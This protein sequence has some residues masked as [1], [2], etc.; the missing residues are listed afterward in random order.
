MK[1]LVYISDNI[2]TSAIVP[3][4]A[5]LRA[6][7]PFFPPFEGR[8]MGRVLRGVRIDRLGKGISRRFAH[9]YYSRAVSAVHPFADGESARPDAFA[10][11]RDGALI[12]SDPVEIAPDSLSGQYKEL[13]DNLIEYFSNQITLKT[14]D[15]VLAGLNDEPAAGLDSPPADFNVARLGSFPAFRLKIR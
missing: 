7:N 10:F 14:G 4:S 15:L 2:Q 11:G 6:V 9:R 5:T 3:D 8:W 13:I 12:V 1:A